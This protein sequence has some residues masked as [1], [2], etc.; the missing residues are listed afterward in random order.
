NQPGP[1]RPDDPLHVDPD[2]IIRPNPQPG[3]PATAALATEIEAEARAGQEAIRARLELRFKN[4]GYE[5]NREWTLA[6]VMRK[7]DVL[8]GKHFAAGDYRLSF[9]DS[10]HPIARV[11]CATRKGAALPDGPLLMVV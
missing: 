1:D 7:L 10:E 6:S 3:A 5:V 9:P 8:E 11:E 4:N 2:K